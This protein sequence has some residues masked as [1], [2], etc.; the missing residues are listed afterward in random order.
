[1]DQ[2]ARPSAEKGRGGRLSKHRLNLGAYTLAGFSFLALLPV[3]LLIG[4]NEAS[5]RVQARKEMGRV[6]RAVAMTAAES[7]SILLEPALFELDRIVSVLDDPR[8]SSD[9]E[10]LARR[11][12][13]DR[14]HAAIESILVLDPMGRS[15]VSIP[16]NPERLGHNFGTSDLFNKP[17]L[18]GE[19]FFSN[20]FLSFQTQLSTTAISEAAKSGY[21]A[22]INLDLGRISAIVRNATRE[23]GATVRIL[24]AQGIV[25]AS[26]VSE[27]VLGRES[28]R[29]IVEAASALDGGDVMGMRYTRGDT[30]YRAYFGTVQDTPWRTFVS[31]T[32]RDMESLPR[33]I[34]SRVI[35]GGI[36]SLAVSLA[37]AYLI[38]RAVRKS[39]D[40]LMVRIHDVSQ[41]IYPEGSP[42]QSSFYEMD[43]FLSAFSNMQREVCLREEELK[44][45]LASR[46][47]LL[48]EVHHR[49][50][51]N[52]QIVASLLALQRE[53]IENPEAYCALSDSA[54]RVQSLSLVHEKLY[55]SS[56][57]S[58]LDL[59][60]Y[61]RDFSQGFL[62]AFDPSSYF[63][64]SIEVE[65]VETDI[66]TAIPIGLCVNEIL[67]NSIKYGRAE[68]GRRGS[69]R[70]SLK[71]DGQGFLLSMADSGPGFDPSAARGSGSLGLLLIDSLVQQ[72]RGTLKLDTSAGTSYEIRVPRARFR[73]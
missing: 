73:T 41:E 20:S 12:P 66:D 6:S 10:M 13:L 32:E 9:P 16:R 27:E 52:L 1:M 44:G 36:F 64:F 3:V 35:L 24:D 30:V 42:I 47:M 34:R 70:L 39:L 72:I 46:E 54:Q 68:G 28:F 67:S 62:G 14:S 63:D 17:R 21:V 65:N 2:S 58:T 48:R 25:I 40:Y 23:L 19:H 26:P 29:D 4:I 59:G 55:Q 57:F 11:Q 50:K 18:T 43:E 38:A 33:F 7:A 61:I 15:L 45:A 49:V 22:V 8:F 37:A 56:D 51:N 60:E 71:K 53:R 5:V 31:F 69:I